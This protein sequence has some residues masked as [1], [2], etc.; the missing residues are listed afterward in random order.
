VL[1]Q[2]FAFAAPFYCHVMM[3]TKYFSRQ[4]VVLRPPHQHNSTVHGVVFT[5]IS[6]AVTAAK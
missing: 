6:S 5:T 1:Q 2:F 4:V 3:P